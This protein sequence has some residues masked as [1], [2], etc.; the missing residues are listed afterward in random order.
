MHKIPEQILFLL[1]L[2]SII[3]IQ[4]PMSR[5]LQQH[6]IPVTAFS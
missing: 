5:N 6:Y 1:I 4:D 2:I 3:N